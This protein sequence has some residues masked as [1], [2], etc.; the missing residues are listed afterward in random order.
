MPVG[1]VGRRAAV[2]KTVKCASNGSDGG[3]HVEPK[4]HP[5]HYG[6][7]YGVANMTRYGPPSSSGSYAY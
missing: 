6:P 2:N 7:T 4:Q 3:A 5:V 1:K